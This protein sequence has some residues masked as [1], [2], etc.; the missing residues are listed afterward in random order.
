MKNVFRIV[1]FVG[2]FSS[3]FMS[4]KKD[5]DDE[6]P[7]GS[8]KPVIENLAAAPS[9]S[10]TYGDVVTL[11]GKFSDQTGLQSY[12]VKIS[13]TQGELYNSTQ[14]LTGKTFSLNTPLVIPVPKNAQAGNVTVSITLKNSGNA[15]ATEEVTLSSV[16]VPVFDNLYFIVGSKVH[17][18]EKDGDVYVFEDIIAANVAGKIYAKSDKTGMFWGSSSGTITGLASGDIVIGKASE[19]N[20][21]ISFNPI[22]FALDAA[23]ADRWEEINETFYI[24]GTI[25]GNWQD[26]ELLT[27][28]VSAKMTGYKSGNK[29]YWT[30]TPPGLAADDPNSGVSGYDMW[31]NIVPGV[32]RFKKAG[33]EEYVLYDGATIVEGTTND[34]A[35]SFVTSAGGTITIKLFYDGTKYNKVSLEAGDKSLD[36]TL[37]KVYINGTAAPATMSFGGSALALKP[38]SFYIYEGVAALTNNQNITA[39]GISLNLADTDPDVFTGKGNA[40]WKMIGST[41]DWLI[42]MDPFAN[43]VYACKETGYPDAI[44][45]DGWSW[46]KFAED[47]PIAWNPEKRLCLQRISSTNTYEATFYNFGWGGD[48]SFWAAPIS[49]PDF[50]KKIISSKYFTGVAGNQ[51]NLNLS[52]NAAGYF[53]VKVDLKDGFSYDENTMEGAENQYFKLVPTGGKVFTVTFTAQ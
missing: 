38:G 37:D 4:C 28:L 10:V 3:F 16:K 11:T 36:Y 19:A 18:M 24:Y 9:A 33:T 46:A 1:L 13:N 48:V 14:M 45:M 22:T 7:S 34:K 12:T 29:K 47:P 31:G 35:S 53:K 27:Q 17:T 39:S 25:S 20:L 2:L 41:G 8:E 50:G 5:K 49:D 40:T 52:P 32:F 51:P 30:W 44:Y 26:G 21:R 43:T 15:T 23:E 6:K 42:R